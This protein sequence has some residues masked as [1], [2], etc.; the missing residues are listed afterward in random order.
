M[1]AEVAVGPGCRERGWTRV[2]WEA[3]AVA[4]IAQNIVAAYDFGAD[5]GRPYLVMELVEGRPSPSGWPGGR[6]RSDSAGR[7]PGLRRAE[8]QTWPHAAGIGL[9]P[10]SKHAPC[11][12]HPPQRPRTAPEHER[13]RTE[14]WWH[15]LSS[16]IR[17]ANR[18]AS[19]AAHAAAHRTAPTCSSWTHHQW[20]RRSVP[21][22]AVCPK[23]HARD[24]GALSC[25][26][27]MS[28]RG[29]VFKRCACTDPTN[30]RRRGRGCRRLRSRG[31]GSW[32]FGCS[33]TDVTGRRQRVRRR[34]YPSKGAALRAREEVLAQSCEQ[35]TARTWTV[36]RWL[37]FWLSTRHSIRP[38]TRR[39]YRCHIEVRLVPY[40][41]RIRFADLTGRDVTLSRLSTERMSRGSP[42]SLSARRPCG[43]TNCGRR[44][45]RPGSPRPTP[46]RGPSMGRCVGRSRRPLAD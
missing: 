1:L 21:C 33:V 13:P 27:V 32:Y 45:G 39:V 46:R 31:H 40:L 5:D 15:Q 28:G 12:R 17:W 42:G 7:H 11:T 18:Y 25:R 29:V 14:Q 37:E 43:P 8:V 3:R 26:C 6:C 38:N 19:S 9:T 10:A 22:S 41:G 24:A 34:G 35:V 20:R 2:W 23:L 36:G 16:R 4:R 30:G 44:G